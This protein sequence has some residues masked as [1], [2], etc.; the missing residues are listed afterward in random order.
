MTLADRR[1]VVADLHQRFAEL[2]E[3][4]GAALL[5]AC[6]SL[7]LAAALAPASDRDGVAD[8]ELSGLFGGDHDLWTHGGDRHFE[9]QQ[10]DVVFD[11]DG[12]VCFELFDVKAAVGHEAA[13]GHCAF[14]HRQRGLAF[15]VEARE[16]GLEGDV[17][18]T[19]LDGT[20]TKGQQREI[21]AVGR[22]QHDVGGD[23]GPGTQRR[24]DLEVLIATK[25]NLGIDHHSD[26][27]GLD[28]GPAGGTVDDCLRRRRRHRDRVDA[29]FAFLFASRG[30][31]NDR[32]QRKTTERALVHEASTTSEQRF[33]RQ[34]RTRRVRRQVDHRWMLRHRC[35]PLCSGR[36]GLERR[37]RAPAMALSSWK[38]YMQASS[39]GHTPG[40]RR[41]R[42][43]FRSRASG[44][45]SWTPA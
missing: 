28:L 4:G 15:G 44:T 13:H 26:S 22:E 45:S 42:P 9:K 37:R 40:S 30:E 17:E 41:C 36:F 25:G 5:D 33:C 10:R 21:D 24:H 14:G 3:G 8:L 7:L 23:Q 12:A 43:S 31:S 18:I 2:I 16:V 29:G 6:G 39:T 38:R 1:G 35:V 19:A 20:E 32:R 34:L 11:A 27:G